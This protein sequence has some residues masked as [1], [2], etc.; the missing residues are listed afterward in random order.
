MTIFFFCQPE[1]DNSCGPPN[2]TDR[3]RHQWRKRRIA[4]LHQQQGHTCPRYITA[5]SEQRWACH[6]RQQLWQG[7]I[8]VKGDIV[9][10]SAARASGSARTDVDEAADVLEPLE[11]AALGLLLLVLLLD[12]GGLATHL[13]GTGERTVNLTCEA[14]GEGASASARRKPRGRERHTRQNQ[15]PGLCWDERA[16]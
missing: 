4:E 7:D 15:N 2:M 8:V 10:P 6:G 1:R 16:P 9:E 14:G 13:T 12:L 11:G 3:D 5:C